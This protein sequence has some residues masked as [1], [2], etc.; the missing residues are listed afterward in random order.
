MSATR[1]PG[2]INDITTLIDI[3]MYGVAGATAVYLIE[4]DRKCLI[5]SGTRTEANRIIKVLR[6]LGAFPPDIIIVTHS[7][8]DHAQGTP[9]LRREAA[10]EGKEIKVLASHIAVPLLEDQSWNKVY[11]TGPY[12]DIQDV[13]PLK[14][15]DIIDLGTTTLRIYEVPGHCKDHIA[16]MDEKYRNIFVG[17]AIGDKIADNSFLPVFMPPYW[18]PHA[19]LS[20]LNK[21]KNINYDSLCLAHFGHIYGEESKQILDEALLVYETWW[22]LFDENADKLEDIDYMIK[23]VLSNIKLGIPEIKIL[24]L[25][26][27]VLFV[28]MTSWQKL[29][30]KKP[31]PLGV[32]LLR[33]IIKQLAMGYNTYKKK[34]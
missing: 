23:T 6:K 12:V 7:H 17:D 34:Q 24:S 20:T 22:Q 32:L 25:K 3:G 27:K 31:Q 14:E 30:R 19:F 18:D 9:V 28:L 10:R 29:A 11:G 8:H 33:G 26:I 4:G 13:T 2:K 1:Q 21:F 15:G 16:I 5:D